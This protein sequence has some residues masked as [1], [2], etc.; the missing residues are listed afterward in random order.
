MFPTRNK[1]IKNNN[2]TKKKGRIFMKT[3]LISCLFA[4]VM[5]F[6]FSGVS[7][8]DPVN[9]GDIVYF[10]QGVGGVDGGGAF[11]VHDT[12]NGNSF[13]TF[14]LELNER[15]SLG[16]FSTYPVLIGIA[17]VNGGVGGGSPDPISPETAFLYANFR[18]NT[19]PSFDKTS[20]AD[21]DS[22]QIA[23]WVLENELVSTKDAKANS[24]IALANASGWTTIGDVRVINPYTKTVDPKTGAIT[25]TQN[26]S[27]LTLVPEPMSLLLLGFGLLGLGITRRKLKK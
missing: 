15:I 21:M 13:E 24:L 10:T 18:A 16:K 25:I 9:N 19:L 6:A 5:L 1:K 2:I 14:C 27:T 12:T 11:V 26:Q 7:M 3:K 17:A 8:A 4:V 23:F 20:T 22:L